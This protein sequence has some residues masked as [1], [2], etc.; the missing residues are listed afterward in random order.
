M[1]KSGYAGAMRM[2]TVGVTDLDQALTLFRDIMELKVEREGDLPGSLLSAWGVGGGTSARFVELSGKG[3]P[4][5]L[6]R[7]VQYTPGAT[8]K[9]RLDFG[10]DDADV[11]GQRDDPLSPL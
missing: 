3:Y 7:L 8:E 1:A 11:H 10:P 6:L 4:I 5:G 2:A 9:V